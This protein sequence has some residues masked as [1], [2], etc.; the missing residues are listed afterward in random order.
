MRLGLLLSLLLPQLLFAEGRSLDQLIDDLR[1]GTP[2]VR[3]AAVD[4]LSAGNFD[5]KKAAPA[6]LDALEDSEGTFKL[7]VIRALGIA[8][9]LSAVAPLGAVL[10]DPNADYRLE[11]ARSLGRLADPKAG[12]VL[13]PLLDDSDDRVRA[14]AAMA[15]GS[16]GV[17]KSVLSLEN[18]LKDKSYL[19]RLAAVDALGNLRLAQSLSSL[20]SVLNDPDPVFR[21]HVVIAIGK[22][23]D[24]DAVNQLLLTWLTDKDFYL[25][26]F[27]AEAL[28]QKQEIAG[29]ETPLVALLDDPSLAV[30]IRATET[31]GKWHSLPAVEPLKRLLRDDDETLRWKAAVALGEIGDPSASDALLYVAHNDSEVEIRRAAADALVAIHAKH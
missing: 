7:K 12:A 9:D 5:I 8:G 11:A 19:V 4:S 24:P 2:P 16:C 26:G 15:L 14:E 21:R 28:G 13:L 29:A 1:Y 25:R 6:L 3:E 30:R 27:S 18:L 10:A 22:L 20:E 23:S 31:L 17:Q